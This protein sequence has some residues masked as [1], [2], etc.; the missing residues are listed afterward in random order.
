M[1]LD[2]YIEVRHFGSGSQTLLKME[3][4]ICFRI[5]ILTIQI[6]T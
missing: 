2:E 4:A 1:L 5:T 6:G 3:S